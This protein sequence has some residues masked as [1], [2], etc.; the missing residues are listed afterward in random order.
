MC[1]VCSS[2]VLDRAVQL[3]KRPPN[4]YIYIYIERE[5]EINQIELDRAFIWPWMY[6]HVCL[7]LRLLIFDQWLEVIETAIG[8]EANNGLCLNA[9]LDAQCLYNVCDIS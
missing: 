2:F 1:C 4:I 8:T 9:F 5:R 6:E 3:S 7:R